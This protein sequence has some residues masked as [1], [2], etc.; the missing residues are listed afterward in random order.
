[1]TETCVTY[2]DK[3]PAFFSSDEKKWINKIRKLKEQ[4]PDQV[5]IDREPETNDGCICAKFPASWIKVMPKKKRELT[6]DQREE[7]R[8]R[9]F[10]NINHDKVSEKND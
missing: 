1:M 10:N 4:F 9:L 3:S 6:E 2:C 7:M 8:E 5:T